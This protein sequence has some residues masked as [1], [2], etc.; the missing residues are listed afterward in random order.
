MKSG[1]FKKAEEYYQKAVARNATDQN[2]KDMLAKINGSKQK[3]SPS[4][5]R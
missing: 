4:S 2:A 1:D 5:P 3:Q